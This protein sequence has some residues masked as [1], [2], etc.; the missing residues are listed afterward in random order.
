MDHRSVRK[1]K[2]D[3]IAPDLLDLILA[4]GT[5]AATAGNLQRYSFVVVDEPELLKE[6]GV[7]QAPLVVVALVDQ[8]RLKRWFDLSNTAAVSLPNP[9]NL[10]LSYWDAII[11]LHNVVVAAESHGLGGYY[12]GGILSADTQ[13][14]LAAPEHTFPAGMACLGY[15]AAASTRSMRLPLRAVVHRN[16]YRKPADDEVRAFYREREKVWD[17]VPEDKRQGLAAQ[18]IRS[19]PQAIAVQKF[20]PEI[21]RERSQGVLDNLQRFGLTVIEER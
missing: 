11:A 7:A 13:T 14:I 17:S 12:F 6:L 15:P 1:F 5:R 2:P 4:A 19:I 18:G 9:I 3:R 21:T 8:Y 10:F 16:R 20:S